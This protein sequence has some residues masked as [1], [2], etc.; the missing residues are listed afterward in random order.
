MRTELLLALVAGVALVAC[1]SK[2][3]GDGGGDGGADQAR[4]MFVSKV[5]PAIQPTCAK[6]HATG[7]RGAPVF[8]AANADGSY[9]AI[10]GSPGLVAPPDQSPL[11]QHGIHSGPALTPDQGQVVSD[12][13][14]LEASLRNLGDPGRPA[15]LRAAFKAF[16][17][18]MDY[19]EWKQLGLDQLSATQTDNSGQCLSCHNQGQASTWLSADPGQ[20]FTKMTQFPYVQRLVVGTVNASGAFDTITDSRRLI[21]K[22]TEAQQPQS[23]SHPRFSLSST[24]AANLTQFVQDTISNMNANRCQ[25]VTAPDAGPDGG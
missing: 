18:C 14:T 22:G 4:Q 21:D 2:G 23:N 6:C 15:N 5:Y 13:L 20:T 17:A 8:L 3:S 24:M 12:W 16:G 10:T 9:N 7:D 25:N 1:G 11:V 19:K